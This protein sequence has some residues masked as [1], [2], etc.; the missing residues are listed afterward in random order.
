MVS[1]RLGFVASLLCRS[2]A[3]HSKNVLQISPEASFEH[4][5]MNLQEVQSLL[6]DAGDQP[7]PSY[8]T[9]V[10]APPVMGPP[11]MRPPMMAPPVMGPP[12]MAPPVK[13]D[14]E[15]YQMGLPLD[16]GL[17]LQSDDGVWFSSRSSKSRADKD[18]DTNTLLGLPLKLYDKIMNQMGGG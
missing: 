2:W 1:F 6:A 16:A 14:M 9:P 15:S 4:I 7:L 10:M 17:R 11:V 18:Y 12:V 13:F 5:T 8:A 3:A